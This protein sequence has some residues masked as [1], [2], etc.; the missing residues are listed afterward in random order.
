MVRPDVQ[1]R[2]V[3]SGRTGAEKII[4]TLKEAGIHGD[5]APAEGNFSDFV[6]KREVVPFLQA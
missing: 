2:V 4:E 6:S 1:V 3:S 5:Y